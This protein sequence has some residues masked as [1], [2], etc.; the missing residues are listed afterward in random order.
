MWPPDHRVAWRYLTKRFTF[1]GTEQPSTYPTSPNLSGSGSHP[2]QHF[3]NVH[4]VRCFRCVRKTGRYGRS[5]RSW[6]YLHFLYKV[7]GLVRGFP[8]GG[9]SPLGRTKTPGTP[10]VQV[11]SRSVYMWR[12]ARACLLAVHGPETGSRSQS[13]QRAVVATSGDV[14]IAQDFQGPVTGLDGASQLRPDS[15]ATCPNAAA[16]TRR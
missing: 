10:A 12:D 3:G 2:W 15:P 6:T 1:T 9:S 8:G 7:E 11:T 5:E 16:P 14:H 13:S 4:I